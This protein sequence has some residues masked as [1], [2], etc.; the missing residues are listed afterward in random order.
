MQDLLKNPIV[1]GIGAGAAGLF[2]GSMLSL[3]TVNSKIADG[4]KRSLAAVASESEGEEDALAVLAETVAGIEGAVT[5]NADKISG[6]EQVITAAGSGVMSRMDA[7]ESSLSTAISDSAQGQMAGLQAALDEMAST[8]G[9][10]TDAAEETADA[11]SA[12][13]VT[14]SALGEGGEALVVGQTAIFAGGFVRAF[15]QS[16][17]VEGGTATLSINGNSQALA[18]GESVEVAYPDGS[19]NVGVATVSED[20]VSVASDCDDPAAAG[21]SASADATDSTQVAESADIG[22]ALSPGQTA[23]LVE[24]ALHVF[25]SGVIDGQARIAVNGTDTVTLASGESVEVASGEQTCTVTVTG[26]S[27]NAVAVEG[28]CE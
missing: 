22:D 28:S 15:V 19:C 10:A 4:V 16:F 27:G 17:D 11:E 20:G 14:E 18:A 7:M 3:A 1:V 21:E 25:N 13:K 9:A 26:V 2:V 12:P 24:N 8:A 5:A 6:L 23:V